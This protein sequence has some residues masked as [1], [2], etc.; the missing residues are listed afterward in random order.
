MQSSDR[1]RTVAIDGRMIFQEQCHGIARVTIELIRNMPDDMAGDIFL[2]LAEGRSTRFDLTGLPA[3]VEIRQT[4]SVVARP[5]DLRDLWRVLR[6]INA[7]VLYA[8]YHALAP[9]YVPCPLVVGVHDCILES[10]RRLARPRGRRVGV[11][12][13]T[14]PARRPTSACAASP[15][16]TPSSRIRRGRC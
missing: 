10:D 5:H 2:I 12:T 13:N 14:A 1:P 3:H 15:R 8:P 16:S 4:S 6:E 9:L 11:K 7:G